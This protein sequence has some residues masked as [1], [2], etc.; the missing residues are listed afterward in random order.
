[1][2]VKDAFNPSAKESGTGDCWGF[3]ASL[4]YTLSCV[5]HLH[6]LQTQYTRAHTYT[7]TKQV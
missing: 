1:M 3:L 7:R 5:L 2:L 6:V 4:A